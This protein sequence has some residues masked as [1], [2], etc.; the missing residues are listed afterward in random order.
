MAKI[1]IAVHESELVVWTADVLADILARLTSLSPQLYQALNG[2]N[3]YLSVCYLQATDEHPH[4]TLKLYDADCVLLGS[5][6]FG[7]TQS[8][9]SWVPREPT[10]IAL[11]R[12]RTVLG[13]VLSPRVFYNRGDHIYF[14]DELEL[15]KETA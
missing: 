15:F 6:H 13:R 8:P 4:K 9:D 7:Q 12:C 14:G 1:Y 10:D 11:D 5:V 2:R 3:G